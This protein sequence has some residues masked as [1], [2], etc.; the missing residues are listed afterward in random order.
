MKSENLRFF[1]W[2][3][4]LPRLTLVAIQAFPSFVGWSVVPCFCLAVPSDTIRWKVGGLARA[5]IVTKKSHIRILCSVWEGDCSH[6]PN[7]STIVILISRPSCTFIEYVAVAEPAPLLISIGSRLVTCTGC[8]CSLLTQF[9]KLLY[10]AAD[11]LFSWSF[12]SHE[13][14]IEQSGNIL[15]TG[16][17]LV[18]H[19]K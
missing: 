13:I 8:W 16:T 6:L 1:R 12:C 17:F 9:S 19:Q 15:Y 2:E 5:K 18:P 7:T 14:L 10:S 4:S 3:P 11:L